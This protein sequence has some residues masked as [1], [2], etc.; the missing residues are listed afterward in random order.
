MN[1]SSF[2]IISF[3]FIAWT[4]P[5]QIIN[6]EPLSPRITGYSIDA[7]LDPS[8]K[9]VHATMNAFWVNISGV[10]ISEARLHMYMN[11]YS[12]SKSTFTE[13]KTV[14]PEQGSPTWAG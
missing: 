8:A 5:S 9:T 11:A 12:S 2:F 3:L 14:L 6:K 4:S 13:R 7:K 10:D 1:K